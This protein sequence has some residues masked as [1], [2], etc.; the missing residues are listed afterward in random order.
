MCD[1]RS[2]SLGLDLCQLSSQ[3]RRG[4]EMSEDH[5]LTPSSTLWSQ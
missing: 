3:M 4:F 1:Y 2:F 5:R